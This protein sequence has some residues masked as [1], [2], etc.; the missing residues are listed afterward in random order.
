MKIIGITSCPSGVAHTYMAAEALTKAA[1]AA[2]CEVKIE[3]QGS[4]GAE[5]ILTEADVA[6]ADVVVLTKDTALNGE[7][8]FEGKPI[9]RVS[10]QDLVKKAEAIVAALKKQLG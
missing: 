9:V 6:S 7:E 10:I 8:R 3:T 1:E 4:V 2:G 5:N